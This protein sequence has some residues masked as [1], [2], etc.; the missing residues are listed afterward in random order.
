MGYTALAVDMYGEGKLAKHPD[1][2]KKFM[3]EVFANQQTAAAR[4]KAAY[5]LLR[6]HKTTDPDRIAAIG[7]CFGGG[8]V[9]HMARAGFDLRGVASFH[10]GL[11][12][13]TPA[14]PGA[15]K[16][17]LLVLTGGADPM[18]PPELV[19]AF[20]K[21]MTEAG[22]KFEVVSYPGA[23]HA[24]TVPEAT[25]K[26]IKMKLPLAYDEQADRDSWARLDT[27]LKAVFR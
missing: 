2:A 12:T 17:R 22:V 5:D 24:F 14:R 27:F 23:K 13:K 9:L 21:E 4:F 8:V 6:Q 19:E 1:E 25:E 3:A 7:Y 18:A 10:G 16:A 20:K 15:V 11:A 26:G